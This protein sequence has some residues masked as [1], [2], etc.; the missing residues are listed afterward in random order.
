[1]S[2]TKI[3][4]KDSTEFEGPVETGDPHGKRSAD[5]KKVGDITADESVSKSGK[6]GTELPGTTTIGEE[7][8]DLFKDVEGLSEGFVEKAATIFEGA[9]SEK[10]ALIREEI[11]SEYNEKLEEA[12]EH[13]AED[14]ENKLDE[15]LSLF[16]ENYLEENRVAIEK[17]FRTEL[18]ESVMESIVGIVESAGVEL[19]DDKIDLADALVAENEELTAKLNNAL[20]EQIEAKKVIR[21]YEIAEAFTAHTEG[22]S[23]AS[24][25][26]LRK[27]TENIDYTSVEQFV[28]KLDILKES[29][30]P[31]TPAADNLTEATE[32]VNESVKVTDPRMQAYIKHAAGL[33]L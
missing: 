30:V 16:V 17:G 10:I 19:P 14:L 5:K 26:K 24:K 7:V 31:T 29:L 15:Y 28:S 1:M 9:V 20:N 25:D 21:K 23:D 12:Y 6:Y 2:V 4:G 33:R 18:A 3:K 11:E 13:I 8:A 22:L 32:P 27:L